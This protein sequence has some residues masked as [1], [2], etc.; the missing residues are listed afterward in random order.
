MEL[1]IKIK[2]AYLFLRHSVHINSIICATY[3][4]YFMKITYFVKTTNSLDCF[5]NCYFSI[6][7]ECFQES[8]NL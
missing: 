3:I 4:K 7:T 6:Y 8:I 5:I 2:V 1:I